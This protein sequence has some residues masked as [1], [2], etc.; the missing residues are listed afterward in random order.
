MENYEDGLGYSKSCVLLMVGSRGLTYGGLFL[1]VIQS[2]G[3]LRI[4]EILTKTNFPAKIIKKCEKKMSVGM[5]K[6]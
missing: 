4:S 2:C 5:Q 1:C 3:T 6:N